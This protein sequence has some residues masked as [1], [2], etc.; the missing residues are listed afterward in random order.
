MKLSHRTALVNI[1]LYTIA[2]VPA[3]HLALILVLS[4]AGANE[5]RISPT[6]A[7][8]VPTYVDFI[9]SPQNETI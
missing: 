3:F 4:L 1:W 8:R 9:N 7:D 5:H 6:L 2:D